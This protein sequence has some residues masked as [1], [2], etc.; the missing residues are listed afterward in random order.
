MQTIIV[1][2]HNP[3]PECQSRGIE[4]AAYNIMVGY[5]AYGKE[6]ETECGWSTHPLS[7]Y[8]MGLM[9]R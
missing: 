5:I 9:A 7:I 4:Q 6:T 1:S 3:L 8:S 2:S